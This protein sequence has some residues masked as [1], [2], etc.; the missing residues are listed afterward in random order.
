MMRMMMMVIAI[1]MRLMTMVVMLLL[2]IPDSD[3]GFGCF[4]VIF[5]SKVVLCSLNGVL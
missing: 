3:R 5:L 2:N 4:Y 1:V